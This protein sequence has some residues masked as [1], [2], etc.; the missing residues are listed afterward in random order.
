[1]GRVINPNPKTLNYQNSA[2]ARRSLSHLSGNGNGGSITDGNVGT[3]GG[4]VGTGNGRMGQYMGM[5]VV[6][7]MDP[8]AGKASAYKDKRMYKDRPGARINGHTIADQD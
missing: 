6:S 3:C 8:D 2:M 4:N 7:E 5:E 1:M